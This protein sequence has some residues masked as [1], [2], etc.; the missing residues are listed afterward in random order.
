MAALVVAERSSQFL[1][2]WLTIDPWMISTYGSADGEKIAAHGNRAGG[3]DRHGGVLLQ[4]PLP[5]IPRDREA[6]RWVVRSLFV[7]SRSS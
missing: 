5:P 1:E 3:D 6:S 4:Q 7:V 2:E